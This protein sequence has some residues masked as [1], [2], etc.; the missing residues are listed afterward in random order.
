MEDIRNQ[1]LETRSK[2]SNC[3]SEE[4]RKLQSKPAGERQQKAI[5]SLT[6]AHSPLKGQE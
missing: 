3:N 2:G 6:T 4:Q 1:Q 5:H